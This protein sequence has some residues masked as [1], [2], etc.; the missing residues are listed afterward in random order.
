MMSGGKFVLNGSGIH[1]HQIE[2]ETTMDRGTGQ[3]PVAFQVQPVAGSDQVFDPSQFSFEDQVAPPA[4][5]TT[6]LRART[7]SVSAARWVHLG[8][9]LAAF[10]AQ[11]EVQVNGPL[12]PNTVFVLLAPHPVRQVQIVPNTVHSGTQTLTMHLQAALRPAP[13]TTPLTF[14]VQ[15]PAP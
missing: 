14:Q 13:S 7:L 10:T 2:V 4:L 8:S 11:V 5:V 12:I 1:I 9:G 3:L 15:P 6:T